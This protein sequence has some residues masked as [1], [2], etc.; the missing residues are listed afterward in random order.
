M[1]SKTTGNIFETLS[2]NDSSDEE[3]LQMVKQKDPSQKRIRPKK[4]K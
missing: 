3:P 2:N 4:N 1:A